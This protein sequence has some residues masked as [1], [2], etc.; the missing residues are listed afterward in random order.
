VR[1]CKAA[2]RGALSEVAAGVRR[3]GTA[4]A[5]NAVAIEVKYAGGAVRRSATQRNWLRAGVYSVRA[6]ERV[7]VAGGGR[8]V[9]ALRAVCGR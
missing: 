3:S 5:T 6:A 2:V 4:A 9:V 1:V 7:V 8:V